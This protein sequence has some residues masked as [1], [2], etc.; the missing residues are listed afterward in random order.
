MIMETS[1]KILITGIT[2]QQGGALAHCLLNQN[3]NIFGLTRNKNSDKSKAFASKGITIIE[4]DLD[5]SSSYKSHLD[6]MDVVFCV[7]AFEQGKDNEIK[8]AKQF[9]DC[10]KS[11]GIKHLV[12]SSVM[13]A[14][15]KTGVPHFESKYVI[16]K[17]IK[18]SGMNYTILRPASFNE[19]FLN[20]EIIKRLEK[21]KL[22]M[23]LKKTV[24]QQFIST[25]DIGKIATKVI[26][27]PEAYKNKTLSIATDERQITEVAKM[28][29]AAMKKKI[30]YQ[31][32]PGLITRL[33][34]GKDLYKMF[35]YMNQ[36]DFVVVKDIETVKKEF[37]GLGN[38]N[39]WIIDHFSNTNK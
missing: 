18:A 20:P 10:V 30:K 4:G 22:V 1:K 21:G 35:N 24:T 17:Y 26:T 14:D 12:Y 28:F 33:L 2:G 29:G 15:L 5:N 23:P 32:L 27:H 11:K 16:E 31:K 25:D 36:N 6:T 37:D 7:Q 19:N 13:G 39:Q 8:Q 38:L 3:V 34:M 9:I